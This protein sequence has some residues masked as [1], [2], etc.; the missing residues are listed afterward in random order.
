MVNPIHESLQYLPKNP[1]DKPREFDAPQEAR[2]VLYIDIRKASKWYESSWKFPKK[3][4]ES[5]LQHLVGILIAWTVGT[6]I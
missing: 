1:V 5:V 6:L 4:L 3:C 2:S